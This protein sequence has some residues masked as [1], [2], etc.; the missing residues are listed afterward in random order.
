MNLLKAVS[1][2]QFQE[3]KEMGLI[4]VETAKFKGATVVTYKNFIIANIHKSSK[5]K[6]H[7]VE[8]PVY[9]KYLSKVEQSQNK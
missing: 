7:Y 6:T 8:E 5:C 3:M 4:K 1:K 9:R 2:E